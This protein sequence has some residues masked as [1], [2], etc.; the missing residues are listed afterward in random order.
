M[1]RPYDTVARYGGEEFACL[2]PKTALPGAVNIAERMLAAVR[3]LAIEH[4]ASAV[5]PWVTI[6]LGVASVAPARDLSPAGLL[7]AADD[8]LYAAKLA[9]RAR[10][11]VA[12]GA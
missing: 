12:V 8:A 1:R 11:N 2:L 6:S 3:A 5:E 7:R 9:G 4:V 10:V